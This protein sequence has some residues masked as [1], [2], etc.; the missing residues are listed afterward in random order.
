M[1]KKPDNDELMCAWDQ[2][3]LNGVVLPFKGLP[4]PP[5]RKPV[6]P[7]EPLIFHFRF[8]PVQW[9]RRSKPN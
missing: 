4:P 7:A 1:S 6:V 8:G 5:A 2:I 3:V 9:P